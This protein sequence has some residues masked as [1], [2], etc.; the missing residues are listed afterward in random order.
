MTFAEGVMNFYDNIDCPEVPSEIEMLWPIQK[1]EVRALM[2][3]YYHKFYND[4][5]NR[6]VLFGINPGRFGAG[7]TGIGFTDPIMLNQEC[8][9]KNNLPSHPELSS[10]F[11]YEVIK[12]MGGPNEFFSKFWLSSVCPVGFTYKKKNLNYYDKPELQHAA[13][14]FIVDCMKKQVDLPVNREIAFSVGRGKNIEILE[15]LNSE[16]HFFNR[17]VA[18]PHPRWVMQY[19]LTEKK[20]FINQYIQQLTAVL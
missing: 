3:Q 13:L 1:E 7:V 14:S 19:K 2:K 12:Q 8:K 18:L 11:I 10:A 4:N 6:I 16:H 5:Q 20:Y 15:K 9:I 17:I